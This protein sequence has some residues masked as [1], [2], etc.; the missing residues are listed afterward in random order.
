MFNRI[1]RKTA[2][3]SS[4]DDSSRSLRKLLF[5]SSRR[6]KSFSSSERSSSSLSDVV[7]GSSQKSSCD[8]GSSSSS[9]SSTSNHLAAWHKKLSQDEKKQHVTVPLEIVRELLLGNL[10]PVKFAQDNLPAEDVAAMLHLKRDQHQ[11]K[12]DLKHHRI[13]TREDVLLVGLTYAGFE[14]KCQN[15]CHTTNNECFSA[16]YKL[17]PESILEA[18]NY[19]DEYDDGI[20]F[21][22][23]LFTLNFLKLCKC[24]P[25]LISLCFVVK[26]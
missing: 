23:F 5:H 4:S 10:D 25:F 6:F 11:Q 26:F 22:R 1:G 19:F 9:L 21:E 7:H 20:T 8:V 16:F 24:Q 15:V 13:C 17:L 14:G 18:K 3:S 12:V 2:S